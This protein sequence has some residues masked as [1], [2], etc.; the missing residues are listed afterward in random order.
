MEGA[1]TTKDAVKR[2][3]VVYVKQSSLEP[4]AQESI[5]VLLAA[6]ASRTDF[7]PSQNWTTSHITPRP[8]WLACFTLGIAA[9]NEPQK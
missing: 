9:Q 1:C 6:V 8:L 2:K 5:R 4:Y 7:A 3:H